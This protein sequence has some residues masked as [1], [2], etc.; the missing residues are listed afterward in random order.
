MLPPGEL[1][2]LHAFSELAAN[3]QPEHPDTAGD[4][5][6]ILR[7][8]VASTWP[9]YALTVFRKSMQLPYYDAEVLG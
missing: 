4:L 1:P 9:T 8:H 3:F 5:A 7:P 2:T 6:V